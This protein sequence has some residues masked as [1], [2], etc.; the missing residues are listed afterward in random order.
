MPREL[1]TRNSMP[2]IIDLSSCN[3]GPKMPLDA[4]PE[5][6]VGD[7]VVVGR[8]L[9]GIFW[10]NYR[11]LLRQWIGNSAVDVWSSQCTCFDLCIGKWSVSCRCAYKPSSHCRPFLSE[12]VGGLL[13]NFRPSIA[14]RQYNRRIFFLIWLLWE[15]RH[16]STACEVLWKPLPFSRASTAV[17]W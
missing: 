10:M 6:N 16:I 17:V 15:C 2:C 14:C 9:A 13:D 1:S 12:S 3:K 8:F 11:N 7:F 5:K 4:W